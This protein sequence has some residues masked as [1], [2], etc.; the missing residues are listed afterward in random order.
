MSRQNF[1]AGNVFAACCDQGGS[2]LLRRR[3]HLIWN[4]FLTRAR[5][6][7]GIGE[8]CNNKAKLAIKKK[9]GFKPSEAI[10]IGF[11]YQLGNLPAPKRTHR[12]W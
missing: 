2:G 1:C 5:T 3:Q 9:H 10:R 11:D 8:G 4:W 6:S 7:N 12:L